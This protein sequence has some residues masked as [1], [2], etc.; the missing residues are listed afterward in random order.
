[1]T[2]LLNV[3]SPVKTLLLIKDAYKLSASASVIPAEV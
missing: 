3:F 2:I 1:L